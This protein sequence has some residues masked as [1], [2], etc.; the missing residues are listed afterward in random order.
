MS[1][2]IETVLI[3]DTVTGYYQAGGINDVSRARYGAG[4][5]KLMPRGSST[6]IAKCVQIYKAEETNSV[7]SLMWTMIVVY[8]RFILKNYI[9]WD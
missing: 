7:C 3:G 8:S 2:Q 1:R 5:G 4:A 9:D 6:N